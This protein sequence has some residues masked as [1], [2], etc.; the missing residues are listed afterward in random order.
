MSVHSWC[1]R[2]VLYSVVRS[3]AYGRLY[4]A[5]IIITCSSLLCE[6][7]AH[8]RSELAG[9]RR[10][11]CNKLA[12]QKHEQLWQLCMQLR[13]ITHQQDQHTDRLN[14]DSCILLV[15][16]TAQCGCCLC[17]SSILLCYFIKNYEEHFSFSACLARHTRPKENDS[18]IIMNRKSNWLHFMWFCR[19][20]QKHS[21]VPLILWN[22]SLDWKFWFFIF[23]SEGSLD[24]FA[25]ATWTVLALTRLKTSHSHTF[26]ARIGAVRDTAT[27]R[28]RKRDFV[29]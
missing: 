11:G 21:F 24:W 19:Q 26:P 13:P 5:Q 16:T 25:F 17:F 15:N 1:V 8:R 6:L 3:H 20:K 28:E 14:H 27:V 10:D 29:W 12:K 22:L 23:Q 4:N 18:L 2:F 7:W 9:W